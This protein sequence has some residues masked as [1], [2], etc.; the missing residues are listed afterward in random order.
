MTVER[1]YYEILCVASDAT[2]EQ[3]KSAY[4]KQVKRYHPDHYG[5]DSE[6]FLAVQ[7]AY[8]VLSDPARRRAYDKA[9]RRPARPRQARPRRAQPGPSTM[10]PLDFGELFL[11]WYRQAMH[12]S[13]EEIFGSAG[14][15]PAIEVRLTWAEARRGGRVRIPLQLEQRCPTC[16]GRG[17]VVFDACWDCAGAGVVTEAVPVWVS[18]PGGISDGDVAEVS[19]ESLGMPHVRLRVYFRVVA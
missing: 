9:R 15:R 2:L 19:L 3:I 17:R 13:F 11:R 14:R 16:G 1:N 4:R 5:K 7:E 18:F 12:P 6:P 10:D 8:E